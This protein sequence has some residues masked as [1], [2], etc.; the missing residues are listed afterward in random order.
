MTAVLTEVARLSAPDE[1]IVH[2]PVSISRAATAM[3][4]SINAFINQ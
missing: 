2:N 4:V 1:D 3:D